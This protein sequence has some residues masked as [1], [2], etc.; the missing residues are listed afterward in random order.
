MKALF[1]AAALAAGGT[2]VMAQNGWNYGNTSNRNCG[3]NYYGR[4]AYQN[5]NFGANYGYGLG[6]GGG[7][8]S[9]YMTRNSW[10]AMP[11]ARQQAVYDPVHGDVH[12]TTNR[13]YGASFPRSNYHGQFYGRGGY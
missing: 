10:G 12:S 8:G 13:G 11:S 7:Y 1:L 9:D 3:T 4:P 5:G 6:Y 2:P